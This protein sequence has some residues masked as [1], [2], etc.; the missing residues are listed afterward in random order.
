MKCLCTFNI[1]AKL[2]AS[3]I[4]PVDGTFVYVVTVKLI[5]DVNLKLGIELE[6]VHMCP[7]LTIKLKKSSPI[8]KEN[9]T[10]NLKLAKN[11]L[12]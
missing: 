7:F 12:I 8:S 3:A 11:F 5:C 4:F 6:L 2:L 10:F 1:D 9:P